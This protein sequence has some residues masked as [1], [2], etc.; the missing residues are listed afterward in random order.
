MKLPVK[1][2]A[3]LVAAVLLF[4]AVGSAARREY[5]ARGRRRST[6]CVKR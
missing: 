4:T 2:A 5:G 6:L 3:M 1:F